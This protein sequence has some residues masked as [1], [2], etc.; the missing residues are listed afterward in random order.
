MLIMFRIAD[1]TI[2]GCY[3]STG[4]IKCNSL[5]APFSFTEVVRFVLYTNRPFTCIWHLY[6]SRKFYRFPDET[7]RK[8]NVSL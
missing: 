3:K 4:A 7:D 8:G 5:T 1:K 2:N 6:I